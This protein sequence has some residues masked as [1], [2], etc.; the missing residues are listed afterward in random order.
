MKKALFLFSG[1]KEYAVKHTENGKP[2]TD[3]GIYFSLSH[4]E[5]FTVCAVSDSEVGADTEKI[6]PIKD[7]EKES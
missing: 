6:R 7:K 3:E 4:T 5:G 2:Y 1:K